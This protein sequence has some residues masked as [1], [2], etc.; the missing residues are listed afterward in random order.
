VVHSKA[1]VEFSEANSLVYPAMRGFS[2]YLDKSSIDPGLRELI[3][4]RASQINQCAFCL[5]MHIGLARK[6]GESNERLDMLCAWRDSP[7]YSEAER[8]ALELTE[9]VTN[10]SVQ[11]VPDTLYE[12]VRLH[13]SA[14]EYVDL[15]A[16]INV[17][18]SWN[19]FMVAMGQMPKIK[20]ISTETASQ[21]S[22]GSE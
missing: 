20:S 5:D 17:I 1:R 14:E 7:Y 6:L 8:V 16:V 19:R 15:L 12:K 13:Y 11:G 2:T 9:A 10:I 4:V 22:S 18:N 21:N 3:K